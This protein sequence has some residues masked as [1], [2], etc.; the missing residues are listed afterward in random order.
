M[1][2]QTESSTTSFPMDKHTSFFPRL[3]SH[4]LTMHSWMKR[5]VPHHF[6]LLLAPSSPTE[7]MRGSTT[8]IFR[9]PGSTR[10]K[11]KKRG[12]IGY[13][14][15]ATRCA[16]GPRRC[17]VTPSSSTVVSSPYRFDTQNPRATSW[18]RWGKERRFIPVWFGPLVRQIFERTSSGEW[19]PPTPHLCVA[20]AFDIWWS[21]GFLRQERKGRIFRF[22]AFFGNR[23]SPEDGG[24]FYGFTTDVRTSGGWRLLGQKNEEVYPL[25]KDDEGGMTRRSR[26][27]G[28]ETNEAVGRGGDTTHDDGGRIQ[29]A[30][31]HGTHWVF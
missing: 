30:P 4:L 7:W 26:M 14:V 3:P 15:A 23:T 28:A 19:I 29:G 27:V 22:G 20:S 9:R 8:T 12:R 18:M 24:G 1:E 16:M 21:A 25:R 6:L 10:K 5:R 11:K 17:A 2:D 31:H 13:V